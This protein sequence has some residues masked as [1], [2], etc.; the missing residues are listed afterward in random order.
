MIL[1]LCFKDYMQMVDKTLA[2]QAV[3]EGTGR[4]L[5]LKPSAEVAVLSKHDAPAVSIIKY[6]NHP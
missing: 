1:K 5:F 3:L 6:Q 4:V 2:G